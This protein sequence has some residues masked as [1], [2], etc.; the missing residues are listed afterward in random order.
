MAPSDEWRYA[1]F[2]LQEQHVPCVRQTYK[3]RASPGPA[4]LMCYVASCGVLFGHVICLAPRLTHAAC[5]N[6][7]G[8]SSGTMRPGFANACIDAITACFSDPAIAASCPSTW[9]CSALER[10]VF[11]RGL[12]RASRYPQR[13]ISTPPPHS[14][15][16]ASSNGGCAAKSYLRNRLRPLQLSTRAT[17]AMRRWWRRILP[18]AHELK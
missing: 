8:A 1:D 3:R 15:G 5:R 18:T 2:Q 10:A 6:D 14:G 16:G 7:K 4:P 11:Q 9:R 12:L 13:S 17:C